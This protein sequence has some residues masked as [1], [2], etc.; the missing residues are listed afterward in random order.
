MHGT[1][2]PRAG[3]RS[4]FTLLE[5]LLVVAIIALLAAFVVPNLGNTERATLGK[6]TKVPIDDNGT[7]STML[8][9]YRR[10]MG[11]YPE[12]LKELAEKPDGEDAARWHGPYVNDL[13]KLKDA[14]GRE[15]KYKSPGDVRKDSYDLWSVGEDG[16]D[17]TD[18]DITNFR[19]Q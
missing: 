13:S 12:E 1:K 15:L 17:Q 10:D 7:I 2:R 19:R 8:E 14:W 9:M 4:A 6:L 5:V 16:E 3:R 11:K 18:D